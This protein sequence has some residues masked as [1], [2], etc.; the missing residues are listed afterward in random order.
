MT[1]KLNLILNHIQYKLYSNLPLSAVITSPRI[2]SLIMNLTS[3]HKIFALL[4]YNFIIA[5][6][7]NLVIRLS[8]FINIS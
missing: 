7:N 1:Y 6:S 5:I 8:Y 4:T 2:A 3:D